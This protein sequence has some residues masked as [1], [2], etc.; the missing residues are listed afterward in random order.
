MDR[1]LPRVG[2]R[3]TA[4]LEQLLPLGGGEERK[5]REPR[6]SAFFQEPR[7]TSE[8]RLQTGEQPKDRGRVEARPVV[9][10]PQA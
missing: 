3:P 8:H 5:L 1:G 4:P 6:L 9:V 10:E 2:H 7:H